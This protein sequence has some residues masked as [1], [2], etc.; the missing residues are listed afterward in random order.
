MH[1]VDGVVIA[2]HDLIDGRSL[3]SMITGPAA[4][5]HLRDEIRVSDDGLVAVS[6]AA[7]RIQAA[8]ASK[9]VVAAWGRASEGDVERLSRV[10]F[11]PVVTEQPLGLTDFHFVLD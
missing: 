9:V 6:L 3:S 7:T 2:A 5:A 1:D 10:A 8:E 4:G 11:D